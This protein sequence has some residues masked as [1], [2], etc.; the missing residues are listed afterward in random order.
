M[1]PTKVGPGGRQSSKPRCSEG[2]ATSTKPA[3]PAYCV[4]KLRQK[5]TSRAV[6][7]ER[8]GQSTRPILPNKSDDWRLIPVA[9]HWAIVD[10][11]D[12]EWV[13]SYHWRLAKVKATSYAY[14]GRGHNEAAMHRLVAD[15]PRS[16]QVHHPNGNGLDNRRC[17]LVVVTAA[18]HSH[19]HAQSTPSSTGYYGV[20]Q[21]HH[22]F[23]ATLGKNGHLGAFATAEDAARARDA[24]ALEKYGRF[25]RLNFPE[26]AQ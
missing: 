26:V 22:R 1:R 23:Y 24:A 7:P 18:E 13:G 14:T 3:L 25:A 11:D 8:Y 17:N 20:H 15:A 6:S 5:A 12:C 4:P 21:Q 9:G 10:K 19:I 2:P 16:K